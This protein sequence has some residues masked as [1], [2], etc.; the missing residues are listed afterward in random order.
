MVYIIGNGQI[1]N[2]RPYNIRNWGSI[3]IGGLP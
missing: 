3:R 1:I 2:T